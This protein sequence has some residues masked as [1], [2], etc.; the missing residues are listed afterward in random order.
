M[1]VR[2][3]RLITQAGV[4][5]DTPPSVSTKYKHHRE[6]IRGDVI[7]YAGEG[8]W[9]WEEAVI[10]GEVIGV[11]SAALNGPGQVSGVNSVRS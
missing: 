9:H 2:N 1:D 7:R 5:F 10:G 3:E 11:L 8:G 4:V 6:V